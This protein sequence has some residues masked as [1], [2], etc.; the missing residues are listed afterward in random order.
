LGVIRRHPDIRWNKSKN[1]LLRYQDTQLALLKTAAEL[2]APNGI[3]VYAT[4]STE[5]EE[6]HEV[7]KAFLAN[8]EEFELADCGETLPESCSRLVDSQGFFQTLPGQDDLDG[9]FAARL[10][11]N[12]ELKMAN[13]K[14]N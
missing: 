7:I 14:K 4:C 10:I 6:N 2:L 8:N 13:N 5:P 3:L 1:D 9:F 12:V 11:K